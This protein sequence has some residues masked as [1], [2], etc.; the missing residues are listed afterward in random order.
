MVWA[1][2]DAVES[3]QEESNERKPIMLTDP[4]QLGIATLGA[5]R[6]HPRIERFRDF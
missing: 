5:L 1:G 4:R 6:D 2:E 3:P